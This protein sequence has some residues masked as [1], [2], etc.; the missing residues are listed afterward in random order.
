MWCTEYVPSAITKQTSSPSWPWKRR[1]VSPKAAAPITA[2]AMSEPASTVPANAALRTTGPPPISRA[3]RSA[4]A[5]PTSCSRGRKNPGATTNTRIQRPFSAAYSDL[6]R[7]LN[8][9][10]WNP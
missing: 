8:A 2:I 9:R 5:R 7:P 6:V 10:I 3:R 4:T 1:S